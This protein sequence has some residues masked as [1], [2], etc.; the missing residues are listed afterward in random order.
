MIK[1]NRQS[2]FA[3]FALIAVCLSTVPAF[4][5]LGS[6]RERQIQNP[7]AAV[8]QASPAPSPLATPQASPP[9]ALKATPTKS[10]AVLQSRI[11]EIL[12][13]PELGS[14]MVGIKVTSLDTGRVVFEENSEKLLRPASSSRKAK[15]VLSQPRV[16][17]SS[18]FWMS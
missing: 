1:S 14:A 16:L 10:L 12:A 5:A 6:R 15:H 13:K 9:P 8:P 11:N 18:N 4:L 7:S 17:R 2:T 3:A